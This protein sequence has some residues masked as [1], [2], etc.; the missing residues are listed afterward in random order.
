ML[1]MSFN[2]KY[3][4]K[5]KNFFPFLKY[6]VQYLFRLAFNFGSGGAT[7]EQMEQTQPIIIFILSI[8]W[9]K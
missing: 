9:I 3:L 7:A 6:I 2:P 1:S 5:F 4:K 8:F